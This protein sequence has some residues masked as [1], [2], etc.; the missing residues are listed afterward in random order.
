MVEQ[1]FGRRDPWQD[2]NVSKVLPTDESS[3][4]SDPAEA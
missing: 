1:K 2:Q 4:L 3:K